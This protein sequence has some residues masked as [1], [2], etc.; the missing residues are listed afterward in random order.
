MNGSALLDMRSVFIVAVVMAALMGLVSLVFA[1]GG[2]DMRALGLWGWGLLTFALGMVLVALRGR[3]PDFVGIL[4]GDVVVFVAAILILRSIRSFD[5]APRADLP[6]WLIVALGG[7]LVYYWTYVTPDPTLRTA[8]FSA[9]FALQYFRVARHLFGTLSTRGRL[10]QTFT[11]AIVACFSALSAARAVLTLAGGRSEDYFEPSYLQSI[12]LLLYI[13]F[14]LAATLGIMWMEIER[15]QDDLL[16]LASID[17]LTGMLNRR[18]FLDA[19][20]REV[21]RCNRSGSSFGYAMFDLDF[22]KRINDSY[23]HPA[24]DSVLRSLA[25]TLRGVLRPHDL[26]GRYGGEEFALLLPG[27]GKTAAC[28]IVERCRQAVERRSIEY[29][30]HPIRV[31]ASAGVAAFGEDGGDLATLIE[32]ADAALYQA[33]KSGRNRVMPASSADREQEPADP[34]A[35]PAPQ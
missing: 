28:E 26:I 7:V 9:I 13:A 23:G 5:A 29:D 21:S 27:I 2:R 22:F 12:S 33:K 31:T 6:G 30:G 4:V 11:A 25:D 34:P 3:V 1:K 8:G 24:G 14:F 16:R 18:A 19:S 35:L 32:A 15:L 17:G 10:S 20:E